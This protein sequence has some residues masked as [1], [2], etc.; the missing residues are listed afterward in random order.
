MEVGLVGLIGS[1]SDKAA[2]PT[3]VHEGGV[4]DW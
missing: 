1:H 3:C 2:V 4:C